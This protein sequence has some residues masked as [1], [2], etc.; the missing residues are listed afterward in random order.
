M[1]T[2][3]PG[4]SPMQPVIPENKG[5]ILMN[6][7][8]PKNLLESVHNHIKDMEECTPLDYETSDDDDDVCNSLLE[9]CCKYIF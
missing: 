7:V 5:S 8:S 3:N 1:G 9:L 4:R 2:G 6:H